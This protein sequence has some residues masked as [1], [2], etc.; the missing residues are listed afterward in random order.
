[1]PRYDGSLT[2]GEQMAR[3]KGENAYHLHTMFGFGEMFSGWGNDFRKM[4]SLKR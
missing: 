4:F 3:L 2:I 1:M